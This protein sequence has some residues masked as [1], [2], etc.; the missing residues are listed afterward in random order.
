MIKLTKKNKI[1]Y[2]NNTGFITLLSVLIVSAVG[3]A[4]VTSLLLQ[5]FT[6][7]SASLALTESEQARAVAVAC[8]ETALQQIRDDTNFSGSGSLT[9]TYSSCSYTVQ[10]LGGQSRRVMSA[11]AAGPMISRLNITIDKLNPKINLTSWQFVSSF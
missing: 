11:G 9:F 8:A 3:L 4:I 2:N 5:G 1:W 7:A 6:S 10:N